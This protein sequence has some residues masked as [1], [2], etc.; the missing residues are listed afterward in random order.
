MDAGLTTMHAVYRQRDYIPN[1][2]IKGIIKLSI[3]S[4]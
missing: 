1:N 2:N 4:L 3:F